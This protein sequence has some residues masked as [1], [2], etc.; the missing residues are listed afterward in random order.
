MRA[1]VVMRVVVRAALNGCYGVHVFV[2]C[3]AL[4]AKV[5]ASTSRA[6]SYGKDVECV[7]G[8]GMVLFRLCAFVG[9]G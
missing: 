6:R 2:D 8:A 7:A 9:C 1:F 5:T 4:S 3:A